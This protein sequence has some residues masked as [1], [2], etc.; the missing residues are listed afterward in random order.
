MLLLGEGDVDEVRMM[1]MSPWSRMVAAAD[2]D[3]W[4]PEAD[5]DD[6][7]S[8]DDEVAPLFV[9]LK[10]KISSSPEKGWNRKFSFMWSRQR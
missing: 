2:V 8:S 4:P 9:G 7:C 6:A 3:E 10:F 5:N 1:A